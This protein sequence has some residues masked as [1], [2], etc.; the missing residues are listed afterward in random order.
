M[1]IL[2]AE[3]DEISLSL[4]QNMIVKMDHT[5]FAAKDGLDAWNIYQKNSV[6]MIITDWHV[7]IM[8][9]LTLCKKIR[10]SESDIYTYI[11][12]TAVDDSRK[13]MLET[14]RS[15]ADD[16][17]AKPFNDEE[18]LLRIKTGER[19]IALEKNH[20]DMEEILKRS[21]NKV[22][23]VLDSLPEQVVSIDKDYC[24]V[25][26]NSA[27]LKE[28]G[29]IFSEVNACQCFDTKYWNMYAQGLERIKAHAKNVFDSAKPFSI[30]ELIPGLD[31]QNRHLEINFLP[32]QYESGGVHQVAIVLRDVTDD[33][34]NLDNINILNQ[35]LQKAFYEI[36]GKNEEL[37]HTLERLKETQSHMV[38][39]E[40]MASIGQLAAGVAH[41]IN[42]PIGFVSSNLKT[43]SGY[44]QNISQVM[45]LY[46][47]FEAKLYGI[48]NT[49]FNSLNDFL[50]MIRK[51]EASLDIEY[52]IE[53][54][55]N[56]IQ[57]SR[58]GLERIKKIVL[59]LKNFSHPGEDE[60]KLADINQ[61]IDSTLNIV[62][63][64][65]KY[66]AQI[67]K[68]YSE[69]P[70]VK[71]YPQQLNQ[72]FMNILVNAAQAIQKN[73]EIGI[74]TR[75]INDF[76]EIII[77][78]TGEGIS[79]KNL[80]RIFDPFFTTKEV[81]KGTGLGLNVAYNIIRKHGGE[82]SVKSQVGKG[83]EFTMKIPINGPSS[84]EKAL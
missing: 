57:E 13:C 73:G 80:N 18:L 32:V 43:L 84:P 49:D 25:S 78:D 76:I 52:I 62:W 79:E 42:N 2:I 72:V 66:K 15:G 51:Q 41:E 67:V 14:L 3:N 7:P 82:I 20:K 53:D 30:R 45:S 70:Q 44:Q 69:L 38:Q 27:F 37:L 5:P 75:E 60:L 65:L 83:T 40:K 58:E 26:A 10:A 34:R 12:V 35:K 46:K 22:R 24:I 54:I 28:K 63:N 29:L 11:I 64:E 71:C 77:S 59:D 16:F 68:D 39:S 6:N 17:I 23:V 1:K 56:L 81:G 61:N 36:Q 4:L 9:G 55:P 48:K 74:V 47:K 21:R 8:D 33:Q 50:D 19:I 31:Q